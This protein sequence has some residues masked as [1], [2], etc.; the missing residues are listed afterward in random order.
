SEGR[1]IFISSHLMSEM[2]MTADRV[3]VVGRGKL[4]ADATM[5]EFTSQGEK[6][7]TVTAPRAGDLAGILQGEGAS[8]KV[9]VPGNQL[10]VRGMAISRIGDLALE[11]GIALHGLT[12]HRSSLEDVYFEMTDD[13]VEFHGQMASVS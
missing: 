9:V 8:V 12:E 5:D 2:A 1:T 11:H 10:D 13:T 4:I 3:I 7:V 6:W